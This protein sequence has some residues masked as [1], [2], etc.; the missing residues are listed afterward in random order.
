MKIS[1]QKTI[2]NVGRPSV[3]SCTM[4]R[5]DKHVTFS[6]KTASELGINAGDKVQFVTEGKDTYLCLNAN[7]G[8]TVFGYKNGQRY[9]S[10]A[11]TAKN[12]V[13]GFLDEAKAEKVATFMIAANSYIIDELI[14]YKI[15]KI[16]LRID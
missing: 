14:A 7:D 6:V 2:A 12:F 13:P 8:L 5:S 16:P 11:V 1:N 3:R 15:I 10:F 4:R 9:T